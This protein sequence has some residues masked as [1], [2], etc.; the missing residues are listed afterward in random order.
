MPG[1]QQPLLGGAGPGAGHGSLVGAPAG[2]TV[3]VAPTPAAVALQL[4]ARVAQ[5]LAQALAERGRATLWVSGGSTPVPFFEALSTAQLD[6]PRVSVGLVDERWCDPAEPDSNEGLVRRHLLVAAAAQ[7]NWLPCFRAVPAD[8]FAAA[9]TLNA[10]LDACPWPAD[11][12][13]L[14]MGGDGHTASWFPET[15]EYLQAVTPNLHPRGLAV[16]APD[17]PNVPRPRF[18]LGLGAVRDTRLL[19]IHTTGQARADLLAQVWA[20]R[21]LPI[22]KLWSVPLPQGQAMP[23]LEV[24]WAP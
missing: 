9:K 3:H 10:E 14:G 11:V 22:G 21:D 13:V 5:A 8:P 6:W 2:V 12:V 23:P 16:S 4:A 24:Y 20:G 15:P 18:T 17:R 1:S 19:C 7:A